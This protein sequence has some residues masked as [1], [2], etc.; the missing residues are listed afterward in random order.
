MVAWWCLKIGPKP[1]PKC[2]NVEAAT[3]VAPLL[4]LGKHACFVFQDFFAVF[5]FICESV[6]ESVPCGTQ[7]LMFC[8]KDT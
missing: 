3:V 6:F 7:P 2:H 1:I 4:H 8:V 5:A